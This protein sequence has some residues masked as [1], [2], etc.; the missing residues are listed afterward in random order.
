M[1]GKQVS[2]RKRSSNESATFASALKGAKRLE[3]DL[4]LNELR[5]QNV[6]LM[7]ENSALKIETELK[8]SEIVLKQSEI[9]ELKVQNVKQKG[10]T[11]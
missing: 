1:A 11:S 4:E 8:Q 2:K 7:A 6:L 5:A 9:I 3:V 10:T